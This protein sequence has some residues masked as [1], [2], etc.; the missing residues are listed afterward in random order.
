MRLLEQTIAEYLADNHPQ[1]EVFTRT[2]SEII[3]LR[4]KAPVDLSIMIDMRYKY[5]SRMDSTTFWP[6]VKYAE[7]TLLEQITHAINLL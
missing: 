4:A 7:S 2:N 6:S 1:W 5:L 3:W